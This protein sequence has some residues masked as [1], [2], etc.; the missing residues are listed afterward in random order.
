MD[1]D[2]LNMR[3]WGYYEPSLKGHLGLQL[4]PTVAERDT[5]TF[6]SGRE[7]AVMISTNGAFHS[8]DCVVSE[9][10]VVPMDYVRDSWVNQREK[11]LNIIPGNHNYALLPETS[12][13]HHMQMLPPPDVSRD[14]R[15]VR[16][17]GSG[18]KKEAGPLKKRT[19]GTAPKTQKTKK[20]KKNPGVPKDNC[21]ASSQR[22]KQAKKNVDVVINGINMDISGIPIPV[23]SCTGGPQQCY[24]WG[25]G[26]WQSAC[27]TTSISMYPLPMSTKRRGARIAGRKMSQGAFKKVLER[28]AS[29]G[30]NF[31]NP[32]DLRTHWAKHGT[33]KFVTIR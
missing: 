29:D 14:D 22:V 25:C 15:V 21:N 11:F 30:Y 27:C 24:R 6:L 33:N 18:V 4:M 1:D 2:G 31:S 12:G 10:P 19:G 23:C 7:N 13:A 3:N 26:G 20:T 32:I 5:K 28:L 9:T 16:M 8:R 17:E